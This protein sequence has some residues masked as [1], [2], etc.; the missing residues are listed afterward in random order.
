MC[1][2]YTETRCQEHRP[3]EVRGQKFDC[4]GS[5]LLG[6]NTDKECDVIVRCKVCKQEWNVVSDGNGNLTITKIVDRIRF[7]KKE[8]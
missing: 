8:D 7:V 6:V 5:M 1:K 3:H 2:E 4:C